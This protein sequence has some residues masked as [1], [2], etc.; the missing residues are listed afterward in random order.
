MKN[1]EIHLRLDDRG[2]LATA[3]ILE[4]SA[5]HFRRFR[6]PPG[7]YEAAHMEA[8]QLI[9]ERFPGAIGYRLALPGDDN[10]PG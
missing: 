8:V 3:V 1:L 9:L 2:Y 6:L 7:G 5:A 10:G 4:Q